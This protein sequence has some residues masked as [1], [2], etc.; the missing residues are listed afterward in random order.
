VSLTTRGQV[1]DL[2]LLGVGSITNNLDALDLARNLRAK[3]S[4]EQLE[5]FV[6]VLTDKT[7]VDDIPTLSVVQDGANSSD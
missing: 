4:Q 7:P 2:V 5:V 3:L 6:K 1:N